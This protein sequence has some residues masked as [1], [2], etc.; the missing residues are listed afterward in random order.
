M[1]G[2]EAADGA[3]LL[4]EKTRDFWQY[5]AKTVNL[6]LEYRAAF[7]TLFKNLQVSIGYVILKELYL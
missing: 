2:S 1:I 7:P 4:E 3:D 5:S 6:I